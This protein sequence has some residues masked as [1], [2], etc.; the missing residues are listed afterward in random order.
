M[1][2]LTLAEIAAIT[3]GV[4]YGDPSARVPGVA[5]IDSRSTQSGDLFVAIAGEHVDGHDFVAAAIA[6]GAA[7]V[8]CSHRVDA[9]CVV[10]GD[11]TAA[12]GLIAHEILQRR[13]DLTVIAITGSQGK[14]S[15]KDLI[16]H[17]L[18]DTAPTVATVGSLNNEL[19]VP[20]TVLSVNTDTRFLVLEMGARGIG[21]IRTLCA[22]ARPDIGV[23]LNVGTAH[24]GEFGSV[25]NIAIA[26][27]ELIEAIGT[28]GT[29]VL[30]ADDPRVMRMAARTNARVL[31]F[32]AEGELEFFDLSLD[33]GGEPHFTLS[34]H[35]EARAEHAEVSV[36]I[37]QLGAHHAVNAAA[38][39]AVGIAAGLRL[40][41]IAAALSTATTVSPMRMA[42]MVRAD[43]VTIIN[44]AYNANPESMSAALRT[45]VAMGG[46]GQTYA[47]LGE[48]LELGSASPDSHQQIG[49]LAADL[50]V[51]HVVV[52]GPGA[53]KIADGAGDLAIQ[54]ADVAAAV[55]FLTARIGAQDVVLVKA[56][57]G[58][59]LER[60][61]EA[62]A[63][64]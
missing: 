37:P 54:V 56:S 7:A 6:G 9:P 36:H 61:A 14:T 45:L 27:G 26:K 8:L 28:D 22:I 17:V 59:R 2:G 32:G 38:A 24:I 3:G 15:A 20:L 41:T 44:D 60:V 34:Y 4:S 16:A 51:D 53:A 63:L 13:D 62:L 46:N 64:L 58:A 30:N 55:K 19:G 5:V 57:R 1:I 39:A 49:R 25:E 43:G 52:V 33:V 11:A 50:G 47:V 35:P 40:E 42:K 48:M 10:V 23:V 29:A 21:H 18:S 12:L 31:T